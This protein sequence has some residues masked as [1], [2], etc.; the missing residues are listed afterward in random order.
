M[1]CRARE[2]IVQDLSGTSATYK[3]IRNIDMHPFPSHVS[4]E[5]RDLIVKVGQLT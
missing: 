1:S 5:A 2:L 4:M 3:R